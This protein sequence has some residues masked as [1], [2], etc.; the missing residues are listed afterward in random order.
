MQSAQTS[1][2][3]VGA[4]PPSYIAHHSYFSVSC[5]V[6]IPTENLREKQQGCLLTSKE[7][8][9]KSESNYKKVAELEAGRGYVEILF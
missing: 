9:F 2:L 5:P 8:L 4:F 1:F 3:R 6:R 7:R